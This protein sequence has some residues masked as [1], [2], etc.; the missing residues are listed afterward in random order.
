MPAPATAPA[1]PRSRPKLSVPLINP[2]L[3]ALLTGAAV[4][5]V[6]ILLAF[7]IGRGCDAVRGVSSCGAVGLFAL[8]A[9]LAIQVILGAVLLRAWRLPDP[10]TTS[11][12]G[13]GLMAVFILF[14]LLSAVSSVWM[15]L[16]IPVLSALT[17]LLA[18]WVTDT[19]VETPGQD[20]ISR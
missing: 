2:R 11:F 6:S 20:S 3:A 1:A 14:F 12:L 15:V 16:V 17:F 19:L 13:V 4:G 10:T 8:L 9:I 7:V 18:L 5:L